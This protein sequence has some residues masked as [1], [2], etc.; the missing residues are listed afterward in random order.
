MLSHNVTLILTKVAFKLWGALTRIGKHLF[1]AY[2]SILASHSSIT[3]MLPLPYQ[4]VNIWLI[5]PAFLSGRTIRP[6]D[7]G[8]FQEPWV[9]IY[10]FS[11]CKHRLT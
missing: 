8:Q 5:A 9:N 1:G 2:A 6:T 11:T 10:A 7:C 3:A 4:K